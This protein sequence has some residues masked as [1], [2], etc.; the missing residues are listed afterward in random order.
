V[1]RL[2]AAESSIVQLAEAQNRQLLA[3]YL[4]RIETAKLTNKRL[5]TDMVRFA[6]FVDNKQFD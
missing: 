3:S 5:A 2:P 4:A 1:F 6:V